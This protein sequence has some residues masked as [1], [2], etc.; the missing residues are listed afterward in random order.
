[1]SPDCH[2]RRPG[3]CMLG[4]MITRQLVSESS[5]DP[6]VLDLSLLPFCHFRHL[7]EIFS[8][9][10]S[11]RPDF[12]HPDLSILTS[13]SDSGPSP[14]STSRSQLGHL[15]FGLRTLIGDPD[16]RTGH[17]SCRFRLSRLSSCY[18]IRVYPRLFGISV[19]SLVQNGPRD[20]ILLILTSRF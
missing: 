13:G 9:K 11:S 19:K 2:S 15:S 4:L 20:P 10:W 14:V 16:C 17:P 3:I 12:T 5:L 18:R 7:G 8:P 1:M 6:N